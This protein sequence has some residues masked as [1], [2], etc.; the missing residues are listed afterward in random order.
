MSGGNRHLETLE[1]SLVQG[2]GQ[3][4]GEGMTKGPQAEPMPAFM[5]CLWRMAART[6]TSIHA[7][8]YT[9]HAG[10][11]PPSFQGPGGNPSAIADIVG[12]GLPCLVT[13]LMTFSCRALEAGQSG[14][15]PAPP[16][17]P[18]MAALSLGRTATQPSPGLRH[19]LPGS[20]LS[21]SPGS[22]VDLLPKPPSLN[23]LST[24][25]SPQVP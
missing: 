11:W 21:S 15:H 2:G 22:L 23:T 6:S 16:Q 14:Q 24:V 20:F 13:D 10:S 3:L 17:L 7:Q 18:V 8:G 1:S 5:P 19:P 12:A 25:P 9:S 4:A